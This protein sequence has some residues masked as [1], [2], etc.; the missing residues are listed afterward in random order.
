MRFNDAQ[1]WFFFLSFLLFYLCKTLYLK[2]LFLICEF[3]FICDFFFS[4]INFYKRFI[5]VHST[6]FRHSFAFKMNFNYKKN[7][8]FQIQFFF[9]FSLTLTNVQSFRNE[10]H[11][12]KSAII[13]ERNDDFFRKLK[14][15]IFSFHVND[16]N[17]INNICC[18][19][20]KRHKNGV[21]AIALRCQISWLIILI[22]MILFYVL[23]DKIFFFVTATRRRRWPCVFIKFFI[24]EWYA[25]KNV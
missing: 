20:M 5:F 16:L 10:K 17:F 11:F 19:L 13:K 15:L 4:F 12:E 1:K 8:S 2:I 14:T 24:F 9:F 18:T 21:N 22:E 23:Y 25:L 3:S 7:F 6:S